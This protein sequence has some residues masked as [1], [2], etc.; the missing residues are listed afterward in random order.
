MTFVVSSVTMTTFD[1]AGDAPLA[2]VPLTFQSH[3]VELLCSIHLNLGFES[4]MLM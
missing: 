4:S 1:W 2:V 3:D